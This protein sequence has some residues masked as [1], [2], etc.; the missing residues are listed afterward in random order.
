M[1]KARLP[2]A[3]LCLP[4]ALLTG[5]CKKDDAG[6]GKPSGAAK[7]GS[8]PAMRLQTLARPMRPEALPDD[9]DD[10]DRVRQ[11]QQILGQL[12]LSVQGVAD[13]KRKRSAI[14]KSSVAGA[15][16]TF[17]LTISLTVQTLNAM[18]EES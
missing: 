4:L 8:H 15:Q 3:L 11:Q 13:L 10:L 2:L 1:P 5:G 6:A 16:V 9:A 12:W 7:T 17:G 18:T 14:L